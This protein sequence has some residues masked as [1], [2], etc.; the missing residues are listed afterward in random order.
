MMLAMACFA[1]ED[2]LIKASTTSLPAGQV[3]M[4]FGAGGALWFAA[5]LIFQGKPLFRPHHFTQAMVVRAIFEACGR[6]FVVLSIALGALS[7]ATV[8]LQATPIV[9][10]AA[11]WMFLGDR[12]TGGRWIALVLGAVGV[13][14]VLAPTITTFSWA[15]LLALVGMF[16][17]AG[18]DLMSRTAPRSLRVEHLGLW[19][20]ATLMASGAAYMAWEQR[21]FAPVAI[22]DLALLG[23]A[24]CVGVVAYASLMKAMRTGDIS[25]VA[26]FRYFRLVFGVLLGVA[27]F[28]EQLTLQTIVG[29]TIIVAAGLLLLV[30]PQA[31]LHGLRRRLRA[32]T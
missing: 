14:V 32:K 2:A 27:I 8:I 19:G 12:P 26:P 9:V 20:F 28:G 3:M 24:V 4:V 21:S 25:A 23:P 30:D 22:D 31:F 11:A 16:G 6:V 10:V 15:S 18:R 17:F 13:G 5:A 7:M 1:I 29:A